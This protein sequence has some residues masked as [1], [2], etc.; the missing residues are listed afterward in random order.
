MIIDNVPQKSDWIIAKDY[1][2]QIWQHNVVWFYK[3]GD[4]VMKRL[5]AQ[6]SYYY[7]CIN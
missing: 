1:H 2:W 6:N 4:R 5:V 3:K 7:Y